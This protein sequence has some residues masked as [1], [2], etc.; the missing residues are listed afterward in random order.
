MEREK[1][2]RFIIVMLITV[3]VAF[4]I[5]DAV[6]FGVTLLSTQRQPITVDV[7]LY[8]NATDVY[9]EDNALGSASYEGWHKLPYSFN[10]TLASGS[11]NIKCV[12]YFEISP[13]VYKE[14]GEE[15]FTIKG[16][17]G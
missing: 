11:L 4:V 14:V 9:I 1:I 17:G 8:Q 6:L 7:S 16:G 2:L 12:Y 3:S 10:V 13:Q 15:T 5:A